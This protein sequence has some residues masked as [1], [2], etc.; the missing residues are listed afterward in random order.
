MSALIKPGYWSSRNK[1]E[2]RSSDWAS[3]TVLR[4]VQ[5]FRSDDSFC[6]TKVLRKGER[7]HGNVE[8]SVC[9][10]RKT[11][12]D[13]CF[14][15]R[16]RSTCIWRGSNSFIRSGRLQSA[17]YLSATW[18]FRSFGS[19][20]ALWSARPVVCICPLLPCS[21]IP[22]S[23]GARAQSSQT[24]CSRWVDFKSHRSWRWW[25]MVNREAEKLE[26]CLPSAVC[27]NPEER[28][29]FVAWKLAT[30]LWNQ[31]RYR[32]NNWLLPRSLWFLT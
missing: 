11:N 9:K 24:Q 32:W 6:E 16:R 30:S 13:G 18:V 23:F 10:P 7:W 1:H 15:W 26:I 25:S 12:C 20:S 31:S 5:I 8:T 3:R 14:R 21:W 17:S 29:W 28:L 22:S 4:S 19:V 2:C 27:Y